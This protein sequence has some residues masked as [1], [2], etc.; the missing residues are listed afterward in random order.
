MKRVK[1][2]QSGRHSA[3]LESDQDYVREMVKVNDE[4]GEA[5]AIRQAQR[6]AGK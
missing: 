6:A 5:D 4:E 2:M 3:L 1:L